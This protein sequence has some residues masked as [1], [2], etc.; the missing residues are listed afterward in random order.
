MIKTLKKQQ[1]C[2]PQSHETTVER[3]RPQ[4]LLGRQMALVVDLV[5]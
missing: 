5:E 1:T 3:L 2:P 4:F